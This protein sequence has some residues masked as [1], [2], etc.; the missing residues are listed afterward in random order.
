LIDILE[1][2]ETLEQNGEA[3][4][5]TSTEAEGAETRGGAC[6]TTADEIP[7][8]LRKLWANV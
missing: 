8:T 7:G 3:Q 5:K 6:G 4:G 2:E 1:S